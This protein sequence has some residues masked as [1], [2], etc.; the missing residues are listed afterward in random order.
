MLIPTIYISYYNSKRTA[1]AHPSQQSFLMKL[2]C[3]RVF[4]PSLYF[5][6]ASPKIYQI[7]YWTKKKISLQQLLYITMYIHCNNESINIK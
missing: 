3:S 2:D 1:D 4:M 5:I 7:L 6:T